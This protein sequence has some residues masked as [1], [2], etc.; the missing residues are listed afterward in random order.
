V[1]P[2]YSAVLGTGREASILSENLYKELKSHGVDCV[3]LPKQTVVLVDAFSRK[4]QRVR[5]RV[6]LTLKFGDLYTD[7][8]LLVSAQLLTPMLIGSDLCTANDII[9]DF[10]RGKIVL[11]NNDKS[12]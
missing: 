11:H 12:T 2:Q 5:K 6:F 7:Q 1:S 4:A 3:E 10:E 8:V 9:L